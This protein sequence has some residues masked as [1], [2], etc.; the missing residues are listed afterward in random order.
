[1]SEKGNEGILALIRLRRSRVTD[2]MYFGGFVVMSIKEGGNINPRN[3]CHYKQAWDSN[4][5]CANI[6]M[7]CIVEITRNTTE[8]KDWQRT[9]SEG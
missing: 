9:R 2:N 4:T 7:C 6:F 5:K 8:L 1:M 3:E